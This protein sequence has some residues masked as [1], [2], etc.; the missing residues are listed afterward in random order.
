MARRSG[1]FSI[2]VG[3]FGS[4]NE[5]YG[6]L[7]GVVVMLWLFLT[8]AV[9]LLGAEL[10]AE[11]ERQTRDDTTEG[12]DQP[13]GKRGAHAADTVDPTAEEVKAQKQRIKEHA[14]R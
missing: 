10:D 13:M 8:A 11:L 7:G 6:S 5:T 2:Y 9:V 3:S 4:Y 14:N 12:R 1:V